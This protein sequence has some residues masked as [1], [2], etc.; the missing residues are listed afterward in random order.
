MKTIQNDKKP[1]ETIDYFDCDWNLLDLKQNFLNSKVPLE[2]PINFEKMLQFSEVLAQGTKLARVD[3]YEI[4]GKL[5]FG[6]IT[7][8]PG[9]GFE[10]FTPEEW[11]LKLGEMI[12][13]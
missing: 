6:E 10:K 9:S 2:K 3:F 8:Y 5:Y 12:E 4:E 13:L 11:D 1:N 7:F